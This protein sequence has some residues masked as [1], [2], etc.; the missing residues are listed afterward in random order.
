MLMLQFMILHFKAFKFSGSWADD[1]CLCSVYSA[2]RSRSSAPT[3]RRS[4]QQRECVIQ[5]QSV[6]HSS[7]FE[8]VPIRCNDGFPEVGSGK[9]HILRNSCDD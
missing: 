5:P 6:C 2:A 3:C 7:W 9:I 8:E 1:S 4:Q